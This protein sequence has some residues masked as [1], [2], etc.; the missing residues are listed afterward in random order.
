VR[1]LVVEDEKK[2]ATS[3]HKALRE[4]GFDVDKIHDGHTALDYASETPYDAIVLDV[5][6]PGRDG[7]SV[8]ERLRAKR[9][10]TP[11]LILTARGEVSERIAGLELGADDYMAKPF[12]MRELVARVMALTRRSSIEKS[13][14]LKVADV[15]MNLLTREVTRAGKPLNLTMREFSLLE[16]LMREPNRVHSRTRLCEQV[17]DYHFD[18]GTNIV[19]VFI[20]RLRRKLDDGHKVKLLHTIRGVGYRLGPPE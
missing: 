3:I 18:P 15:V 19:D 17:W 9:I 11:V 20:T 4:T 6:L 12:A 7:L 16:F 5:M 1:I 10:Y 13:T 14:M 2:I 8:L